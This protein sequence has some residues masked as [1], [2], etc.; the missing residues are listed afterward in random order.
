MKN[1]TAV[2]ERDAD[3]QRIVGVLLGEARVGLAAAA[4]KNMSTNGLARVILPAHCV[5]RSI[6]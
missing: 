5:T 4:L 6:V 3:T 1:F 2:V